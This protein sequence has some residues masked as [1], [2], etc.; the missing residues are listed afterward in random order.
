MSGTVLLI[1]TEMTISL[2]EKEFNC[3]VMNYKRIIFFWLFL[4][5][6][7]VVYYENVAC[8]IESITEK[9]YILLNVYEI[10]LICFIQFQVEISFKHPEACRW[11]G[12]RR[13]WWPVSCQGQK[14]AGR[15]D[16][17]PGTYDQ[18]KQVPTDISLFFLNHQSYW[19]PNI[20]RNKGRMILYF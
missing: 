2:L 15:W 19:I 6:L 10:K 9:Q 3:I 5:F 8:K 12:D 14:A 4:L 20:N 13:L 11:Q 17:Q 16:T 18:R 1:Q 7:I